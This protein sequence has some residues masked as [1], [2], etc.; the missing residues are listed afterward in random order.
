[1]R[2]RLQI[3]QFHGASHAELAK[4]LQDA[5]PF[6]FSTVFGPPSNDTDALK[7]FLLTLSRHGPVIGASTP[8]TIAQTEYREDHFVAIAYRSP[9]M[10]PSV[11][12]SPLR[13][14]KDGNSGVVN[15]V[16]EFVEQLNK[17]DYFNSG[18]GI[19]GVSEGAHGIIYR[20]P[21]FLLLFLPG[22][23][24]AGNDNWP[25][26]NRDYQI[27]EILS[28]LSSRDLKIFGGSAAGGWRQ[29]DEKAFRPWVALAHDGD[30]IVQSSG[31]AGMLVK[32]DLRFGCSSEHGFKLDTK[33]HHTIEDVLADSLVAEEMESHERPERFHLAKLSN[34]T[35]LDCLV[36]LAESREGL[37]DLDNWNVTASFDSDEIYMNPP[38]IPMNAEHKKSYVGLLRP[39]AQGSMLYQAHATPSDVIEATATATRGA[40]DDGGIEKVAGLLMINCRGRKALI[41]DCSE[42]DLEILTGR[43]RLGERVFGMYGDGE[44]CPSKRGIN[45]HWNWRAAVLALGIDYNDQY[46]QSIE[47]EIL[48]RIDQAATGAEKIP[49][50]HHEGAVDTSNNE[51]VLPVLKAIT[52]AINILLETDFCHIRMFNQENQLVLSHGVGRISEI[53]PQ[54]IEVSPVLA[55]ARNLTY[56]AFRESATQVE[57]R[58]E[59]LAGQMFAD[60]TIEPKLA[61]AEA[62]DIKWWLSV[63]IIDNGDCLGVIGIDSPDASFITSQDISNDPRVILAERIAERAASPIRAIL[64]EQALLSSVTIA[65]SSAPDSLTAL[66]EGVM[67]EAPLL[68]GRRTQLVF[69]VPDSDA[70]PQHLRIHTHIGLDS[71]HN[72]ADD[73]TD[74][75]MLS[76]D[77]SPEEIGISGWMFNNRIA[78]VCFDDVDAEANGENDILPKYKQYFNGIS[79]NY[80]VLLSSRDLPNQS[81]IGVLI[82]EAPAGVLQKNVHNKR[83]K[84]IGDAIVLAFE[85][86]QQRVRHNQ[87][88]EQLLGQLQSVVPPQIFQ[89]FE[90]NRLRKLVDIAEPTQQIIAILVADIKGYSELSRI[91]GEARLLPFVNEFYSMIGSKV[92]S[93]RGILNRYS[94]SDVLALY[95]SLDREIKDLAYENCPPVELDTV[96]DSTLHA[97]QAAFQI[98]DSFKEISRKWLAIWRRECPA[99]GKTH[100]LDIRVAIHTGKPMVGFFASG[101]PPDDSDIGGLHIQYAAIG[102]DVDLAAEIAHS[103]EINSVWLTASAWEHLTHSGPFNAQFDLADEA[104][105]VT[106][107]NEGAE[108]L[109]I[110]RV[111]KRQESSESS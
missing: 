43:F 19:Q 57:T 21:A 34:V 80:A 66:V 5:E 27:M 28:S 41:S 71:E 1:M 18:K 15:C 2:E 24:A 54:V 47:T 59:Y 10:T 110:I 111:E 3:E 88:R 81:P 77:A 23:G 6:T 61:R 29:E 64:M 60:W 85:Q 8:H 45:S 35:D 11:A 37:C 72:I 48:G 4:Q 12:F 46:R 102:I 101:T 33:K 14:G 52:D 70:N 39:V 83:L 92:N 9:Y 31:I 95:S 67:R 78:E 30:V 94:G 49:R 53:V 20:R 75:A 7:E 96:A 25:E 97:V 89:F 26:I 87:E 32:S 93:T 79:A 104:A 56:R 22:A 13:A 68:L 82:A 63:P 91:I 73:V 38:Y 42:Q 44:I 106:R 109:E 40:I 17:P 86:V 16:D 99:I 108:E 76:E 65:A 84:K 58:D 55:D 98:I 105:T 69:L 100:E 62:G 50:A 51:N 90:E 36:P 107:E 74:I 103:V